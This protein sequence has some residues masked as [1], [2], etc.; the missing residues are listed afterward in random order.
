LQPVNLLISP[1]GKVQ[2]GWESTGGLERELEGRMGVKPKV[3]AWRMRFNQRYALADGQVLKRVGPPYPAERSDYLFYLRFGQRSDTEHS[4]VF[5]WDGSLRHRGGMGIDSLQQVLG[6]VL[7]FGR[8][9]LDGPAELLN[10]SV[11]GDW[12]VRSG[13][14]RT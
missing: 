3:P 10:M 8:G 14:S 1:D 9:E 7:N 5:Y 13:A 6:F 4:E 12:V 2:A 11:P